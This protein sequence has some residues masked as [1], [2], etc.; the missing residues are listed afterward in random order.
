MSEPGCRWVVCSAQHLPITV[1]NGLYTLDWALAASTRVGYDTFTVLGGMTGWVEPKFVRRQSVEH[2]PVQ[3]AIIMRPYIFR[4][5]L[6]VTSSFRSPDIM[7]LFPGIARTS[8]ASACWDNSIYHVSLQSTVGTDLVND[9]P[10]WFVVFSF[11]IELNS[12][13]SRANAILYSNK[14]KFCPIIKRKMPA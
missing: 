9:D 10:L 6:L 4:A 11:H 5:L 13:I 1:P 3:G 2:A 12:F 8:T 7:S 14:S